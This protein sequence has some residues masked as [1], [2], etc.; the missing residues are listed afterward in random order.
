[1]GNAVGIR[2]GRKEKQGEIHVCRMSVRVLALLLVL[3]LLLLLFDGRQHWTD[4]ARAGIYGRVLQFPACAVLSFGTL[5]R[6]SPF[7]RFEL[8]CL[9]VG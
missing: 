7:F 3:V 6:F 4:W 9:V 8:P 2:S 5:I 1:M